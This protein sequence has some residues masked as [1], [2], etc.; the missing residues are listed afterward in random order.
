MAPALLAPASTR[1]WCN[2]DAERK[3]EVANS[4]DNVRVEIIP[5]KRLIE[6]YLNHDSRRYKLE[7]FFEDNMSC[8]K[9]S[10]I[11]PAESCCSKMLYGSS[12]IQYQMWEHLG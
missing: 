3:F 11:G 6:L 4:C 2:C 7:V 5:W 9:C 10:L 1:P 12:G 8:Y